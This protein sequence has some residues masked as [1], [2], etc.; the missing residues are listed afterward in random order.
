MAF[1]MSSNFTVGLEH[2]PNRNSAVL[3]LNLNQTL[4]LGEVL[5]SRHAFHLNIL[6][7]PG[8]SL[9]LQPVIRGQFH[10]ALIVL[11]A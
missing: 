6:T 10:R 5:V 4:F 7:S 3:F 1:A 2:D 9:Q 8:L 11:L